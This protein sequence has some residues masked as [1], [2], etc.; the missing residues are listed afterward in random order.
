MHKQW[1]NK[2]NCSGQAYMFFVLI[3][4]IDYEHVLYVKNKISLFSYFK[5][6]NSEKKV[7]L[8]NKITLVD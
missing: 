7:S 3:K 1:L 5:Q 6:Y 4:A 8:A 2:Y